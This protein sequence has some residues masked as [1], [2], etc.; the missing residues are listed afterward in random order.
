MTTAAAD[1]Q[2]PTPR[3]IHRAN[4][5]L[6]WIFLAKSPVPW[7]GVTGLSTAAAALM[8][9]AVV[10]DFLH[11]RGLCEHCVNAMPLDGP[12]AAERRLPVLRAA[13]HRGR[14]LLAAVVCFTA[15]F[16]LPAH[17]AALNAVLSATDVLLAV[18]IHSGTTHNRLYPWCPFCHRGGGGGDPVVTPEPTGDRGRPVPSGT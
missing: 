1:S 12:A 13:H 16:F 14:I 15:G 3:W 18:S 7:L 4:R 6:P 2:P 5:A 11:S 10:A 8:V 17:S 9:A